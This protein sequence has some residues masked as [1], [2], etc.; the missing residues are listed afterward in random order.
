MPEPDLNALGTRQGLANPVETALLSARARSAPGIMPKPMPMSRASDS[1][2][3]PMQS[4]PVSPSPGWAC[5]RRAWCWYR[6]SSLPIGFKWSMSIA[7]LIVVVMGVLGFHLIQQQEA[8]YRDQANRFSEL[9]VE[10]LG[11]I[12]GEPLMAGDELA[13]QVLLKRHAQDP[14]I[15]GVELLD[16]D[17]ARAAAAG[18]TPPGVSASATGRRIDAWEWQRGDHVAASYRSPV[19]YQDVVAGSLIVSF[20]RSQLEQRIQTTLH[21]LVASTL[22]L[23]TIGVGLGS[24]L[25]YRLS[26]PIQALARAGDC[27]DTALDPTYGERRDELGQMLQTFRR[28]AED[29]RGRARAEDALTRY[30][31]AGVARQVLDGDWQMVPG[32]SKVTGSV[33]FC[34]IVGF[35]E[36][37]EEREPAEVAALLNDYFGYFAAAAESCGGTVD[38]FIGDCIMIVFG[39]PD[40]HPHHALHALTCGM[41]IQRLTDRISQLRAARGLPTVRCRVG[42]SSGSMLAGHLGSPARLQFTVVGDT[43]NVAARL[44]S[45]ARPGGVLMNDNMLVCGHPGSD[46]CYRSLG[47][48]AIR[49][50]REPVVVR[51]MDVEAVAGDLDADRLIDGILEPA[52][53]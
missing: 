38:K 3:I 46:Q 39:V 1:H 31:S 20:D 18:I 23:I 47:A 35:T 12:S 9:I 51:E 22:L 30:V 44:C 41:L 15:L 33:L 43:V 45:M 14:L 10:Q 16:A 52:A 42:I 2:D 13:L 32:G 53:V 8:G 27:I 26:R 19:R 21:F 25:A 17:G 50:R 7:A 48:A 11:R 24:L 34:D 49:G 4:R 29:V 28:L 36:L 37:S 5:L 6:N 40:E